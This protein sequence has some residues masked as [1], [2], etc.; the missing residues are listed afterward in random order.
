MEE[1][2]ECYLAALSDL[3]LGEGVPRKIVQLVEAMICD[4]RREA[5][6]HVE[7]TFRE[8]HGEC[9]GAHASLVAMIELLAEYTP[10]LGGDEFARAA[11]EALAAT[12]GELSS[13]AEEL[14]NAAM[15]YNFIETNCHV[16]D[17]CDNPALAVTARLRRLSDPANI[18][19]FHSAIWRYATEVLRDAL[20]RGEGWL[21]ALDA[22]DLALTCRVPHA[23]LQER[24]FEKFHAQIRRALD[25]AIGDVFAQVI[26][27]A[28]A[29][30][31]AHGLR[32]RALAALVESEI[33]PIPDGT[34]PAFVEAAA[35]PIV[36][37][38][39]GD[40]RLKFLPKPQDGPQIDM[41][42][43]RYRDHRLAHAVP[44]GRS[45]IADPKRTA[46]LLLDMAHEIGHAVVLQGAI[47][48]R[49]ALYRAVATYCEVMLV[50]LV[51]PDREELPLDRLAALAEL[52][53]GASACAFADKQL[54]AV[55]KGAVERAVWRSWLE[56]VSLYIELLCDP[57]DDPSEIS[58]VH[59]CVRGLIDFS[60][61]RHA[62]ES[63]EAYLARYT[64][65]V[66]VQFEN[67]MSQAIAKRSRLNHVD[68]ASDL[69][70][71]DK[72]RDI[73]L[74]GYLVVRAV[75]SSWEKTLGR[76][77]PPGIAVKLLLDATQ[78]GTHGALPDPLAAQ[79]EHWH[80][81]QSRY[82]AWVT[83]LARLDK[84]ALESF[85]EPI[86]MGQRGDPSIWIGGKPQRV[87]VVDEAILALEKTASDTAAQ[88]AA[89]LAG[90][91]PDDPDEQAQE[92]WTVL[93]KLLAQHI[94]WN[95]FL[96]IGSDR[97]RLMI[98][99]DGDRACLAIRTYGGDETKVAAQHQEGLV[100][101]T[102]DARYHIRIMPLDGGLSES[103]QLRIAFGKAGTGRAYATRMIDLRGHP[104]APADFRGA[105]YVCVFLPSGYDCVLQ[106]Q[107]LGVVTDAKF[108]GLLRSRMFPPFA[109]V[110]EADSI[111]SL[112]FLGRRAQRAQCD[113]PIPK[114][115]ETDILENLARDLAR[116]AASLAF[117]AAT[118]DEAYDEAMPDTN[119][120]TALANVL[121][122]S[123]RGLDLVDERALDQPSLKS[124]R[125]AKMIFVAHAPS[126]VTPFGENP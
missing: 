7:A 124:H 115:H 30:T 108:I 38:G 13:I 14:G 90:I 79:P 109:F 118:F 62:E 8:L 113:P 66:V 117:G 35:A 87:R 11:L 89:A 6:R 45:L 21:G 68:Y 27:E 120:R 34:P 86:E 48:Q 103:E 20:D 76:R 111:A 121:F 55:E 49:Q 16:L 82:F 31:A 12:L 59:E 96:P 101:D 97:P 123:G 75:V 107:T 95:G 63:D 98:F 104:A 40:L 116:K 112:E 83:D 41:V 32:P 102:F 67:F 3:L 23:A 10:G 43:L 26:F 44:V 125:L 80:E 93:K 60:V 9:S 25:S 91:D 51:D 24:L 69:A 65:E 4:G 52:P 53:A 126:I 78:L 119:F 5:G 106:G 28:P 19:Q 46:T 15:A 81:A 74:L 36:Q 54:A 70:A 17:I 33:G 56:G 92:L 18:N 50:G 2:V 61:P 57:K 114:T 84:D 122:A 64:T 100:S 37:A 94:E 29:G 88:R 110:G 1:L 72:A 58:T 73:Y 99:E 105:S 77:L 71:G 42:D 22:I 47:G 39:L 85:F